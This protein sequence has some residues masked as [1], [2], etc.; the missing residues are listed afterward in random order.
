MTWF[1]PEMSKWITNLNEF[2]VTLNFLGTGESGKSTFIKQMRIIHGSGF[3]EE[4][5]RTYIK[6]VYQNIFMAMQSMIRAMDLLK[7]QYEDGSCTVSTR[8]IIIYI[9]K[10]KCFIL[11]FSGESW[12]CSE[13]W[14]RNG[15]AVWEPLRGGDQGPVGRP[16][17]PGVLRPQE[18]VSTDRLRQVVSIRD[19]NVMTWVLKTDLF[20]PLCSVA[21]FLF[22]VWLNLEVVKKEVTCSY[23][24]FQLPVGHRPNSF[25]RLPS[26][27]A[28]HSE[29]E[30]AHHR[31]HRIPI[32]PRRNQIQVS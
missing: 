7:I 12:A 24:C 32:W 26:L 5:K 1:T 11:R 17:D 19:F 22:L 25:T 10:R 29:S 3:N 13:H 15:D 9:D 8:E 31:H 4:D 14:L 16:R 28:G 20:F 2:Q 6:L 23:I 30:G 21:E 18:G 27:A